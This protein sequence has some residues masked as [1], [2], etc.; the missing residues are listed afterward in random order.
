MAF[1]RVPCTGRFCL[2]NA[3]NT[4]FSGGF[5]SVGVRPGNGR[6]RRGE[7]L[8]RCSRRGLTN[9]KGMLDDEGVTQP[10]VST[11]DEKPSNYST[12][13]WDY[14]PWWC[15]PYSI[16]ST[17]VLAVG[18][19]YVI[20]QHS[21]WFTGGAALFVALWWNTFLVSYP[22]EFAAY[23]QQEMDGQNSDAPKRDREIL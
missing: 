22:A 3:N 11:S 17:G 7:N 16:I 9:T 10:Q 18:F 6:A 14:K 15:Q 1:I 23:I 13:V 20:F 21:P 5:S 2:M 19:T 8:G 4:V 12:N